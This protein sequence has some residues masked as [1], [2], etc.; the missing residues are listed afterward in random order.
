MEFDI[1]YKIVELRNPV[2][3]RMMVSISALGNG[4]MV[5][6]ILTIGMLIF[7]KTRKCGIVMALSLILMLLIGNVGL[8]NL[9]QRDRP[10]WIDTSIPMLIPI[11]HDYS[12]PSGHTYASFAAATALGLHYKKAGILAFVLAVLI[13]FS[14]MYLFVHFFTDILG[15]ILLGIGTAFLAKKIVEQVVTKK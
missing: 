14:R 4:G 8:K 10:C 13:A 12:F 3:D 2:L 6:I 9:I 7:K 5:W 15:G 1:L 11:P